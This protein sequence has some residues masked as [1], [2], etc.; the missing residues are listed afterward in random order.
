MNTISLRFMENW[1]IMCFDYHKYTH[2]F[3][4]TDKLGRY[5]GYSKYMVICM[6]N[7]VIEK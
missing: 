5:H 7:K 4:T 6:K 1:P 2:L 3:W